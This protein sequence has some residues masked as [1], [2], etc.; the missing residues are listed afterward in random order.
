MDLIKK[1]V[2]NNDII[3]YDREIIDYLKRLGFPILYLIKE[4]TKELCIEGLQQRYY[5]AESIKYIQNKDNNLYLE[6]LRQN[7]LALKY[8]DRQTDEICLEAVKQNGMA[9]EYVKNKK[10]EICLE[11]VKQNGL[12]IQFINNE[13]YNISSLI[14]DNE[15]FTVK[16]DIKINDECIICFLKNNN[17]WCKLKC[18]HIFHVECILKWLKEKKNCPCCRVFL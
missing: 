12:A 6:S 7:G 5:G 1:L 18:D 15:Y 2:Y 3:V 14:Y 9:L 17:V 16:K 11:A 8:I 13:K 4:P 10:Y